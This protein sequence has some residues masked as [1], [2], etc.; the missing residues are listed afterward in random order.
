MYLV[1]VDHF[2]VEGTG[3]HCSSWLQSCC[4]GEVPPSA[5]VLD[6][7]QWICLAS[8][9]VVNRLPPGEIQTHTSPVQNVPRIP[10]QVFNETVFLE[11]KF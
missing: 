4:L 9:L 3:E 8:S 11:G 7:L 5:S 6:T 10:K 2:S 1:M